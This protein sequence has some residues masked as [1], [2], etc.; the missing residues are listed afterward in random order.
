MLISLGS[1]CRVRESIDRFNNFRVETNFFDWLITNFATV[2]FIIQNIDHPQNFLTYDKFVQKGVFSNNLTHYT[3]DHT[4]LYFS[5]LHDFPVNMDYHVY[6]NTFLDKYKRR[7]QRLK[8]IILNNEKIHFIHMICFESFIPSIEQIY[9]FVTKIKELN[10]NCNFTLHLL[11]PPELHNQADKINLL[12]ICTNV[13]I[14]YMVVN[15]PHLIESNMQR[16]EL[17][18]Q[19]IYNSFSMS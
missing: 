18:W 9:F 4:Q 12:V 3:V 15:S 5:S 13:K 11:I 10:A 19:D 6:M 17:N 7:L 8:N 14:H 16:L 2:L 1:A